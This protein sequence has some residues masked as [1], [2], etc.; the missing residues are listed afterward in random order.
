MSPPTLSRVVY[1]LFESDVEEL[2]AA[3][4]TKSHTI[5]R[6]VR[7]EFSN[8]G[9]RYISWCSEPEQYC[10]GVKE[11]S[12]FKPGGAVSRDVSDHPL[13]RESVGRVVSLVVLDAEHQILEVRAEVSSTYLSTQE[14]GHWYSDAVTI[15]GNKPNADD[16]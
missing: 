11:S 2:N 7:L 8:G 3:A 16:P 4:A 15:S 5:D 13:W 1:E 6:E 9:V 14:N 12:F 10:I